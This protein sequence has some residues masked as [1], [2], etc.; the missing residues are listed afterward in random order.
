[1]NAEKD[2]FKR[3][4]ATLLTALFLHTKNR[5]PRSTKTDLNMYVYYTQS[6]SFT[7]ALTSRH[8]VWIEP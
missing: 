6:I 2:N 1:M 5:K 4:A 7:Q 8:C 3:D